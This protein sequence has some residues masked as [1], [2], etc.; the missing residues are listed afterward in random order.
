MPR[1]GVVAALAAWAVLLVGLLT[2]PLLRPGQ[3]AARDMLVLDHP[4]LTAAALGFGDLAARNVVTREVRPGPG[5]AAGTDDGA[6]PGAASGT[7]SGAGCCG[8]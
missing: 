8:D 1:P 5:G 2:W 7:G 6:G 4:A 3:L